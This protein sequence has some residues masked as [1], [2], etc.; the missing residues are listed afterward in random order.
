MTE[1]F[2][3]DASALLCLL[4]GEQGAD[5]VIA[6]LPRAWVCAV[7]LTE[8]YA[9]LAYAGGTESRIA[10]A[11]GGLYL[12]VEAFDD[13]HARS[14]GMLRPMTKGFGLSLGDHACLALARHRGAIALTTDRGWTELPDTLGI[15]VKLLR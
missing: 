12:R 10:Q 15:T 8:V 3:L 2:V 4:K 1:A 9:K 13:A 6:C 11:I 5:R 14:A 7:N